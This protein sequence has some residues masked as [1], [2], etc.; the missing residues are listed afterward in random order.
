MK[1][2]TCRV[3][4][5]ETVGIVSGGRLIPLASG[6]APRLTMLDVIRRFDVEELTELARRG[7]EQSRPLPQVVFEP[8]LPRPPRNIFCV[9]KNYRAHAEEFDRSG[10]TGSASGMP[11]VPVVFTKPPEALI[12]HGAAICLPAGLTQALDYEAE[13]AVVI[14]RP[15]RAIRPADAGR[16][17]FGYTI[18]NDVTA[19]DVQARHQQWFLGK[20]LDASCPIGP[21]IVT[22]DEIGSEPLRIRCS[23][24]GELRQ[25]ASTAEL[26]FDVPTLIAT[27]SAVTALRAGDVIATGTPAGVGIGF[28]TPRYLADGDTVEIEVSSIGTLRNV[29]RVQATAARGT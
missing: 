2:A 13:V 21:W 5:T 7:A 9:G 17:I 8:P 10:V 1:L 3:D 23:V 18:L 16:H 6:S 24:N 29:V 12:G 19:R 11:E 14:G 27:I 20:A 26:I 4:G 22:A 25:E 28:D 15:G